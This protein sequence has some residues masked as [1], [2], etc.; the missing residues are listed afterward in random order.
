MHWASITK[1]KIF[2]EDLVDDGE[3]NV[4]QFGQIGRFFPD[5]ITRD[6][7]GDYLNE[8]LFDEKNISYNIRYYLTEYP[9][10]LARTKFIKIDME[11]TP[12]FCHVAPSELFYKKLEIDSLSSESDGS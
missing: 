2:N 12:L 4:R 10:E 1:V 5:P 6:M 7:V 8:K 9:D 3:E 11:G